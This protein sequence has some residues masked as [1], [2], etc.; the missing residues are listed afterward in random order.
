MNMK[1]KKGKYTIVKQLGQGGF[2]ITYLATTPTKVEGI[3]NGKKKTMTVTAN[4]V[5]KEFFLKDYCTREENDSVTVASKGMM[6]M[7]GK[8][9]EKFKK[10]AIKLSQMSHPNIVEVT[11]VI[12]DENNTSYYI[13]KYLS[14]GTL[15]Q[16]VCSNAKALKP[17]S[18]EDAVRYIKQVASALDYMHKKSMCHFD[19]KPNNIM[20]DEDGNAVLIDFGLAKN[21]TKEGE[22]TSTLISGASVGYAPLEQANA[23]LETFSP[24]TDIYA[25]GATLYFLLTGHAPKA[26]AFNL[27]EVLPK[28]QCGISDNLWDVIKGS[29]QANPENRPQN[30]ESFLRYLDGKEVE[31]PD[32]GNETDVIIAKKD[33]KIRFLNKL[34]TFK[35]IKKSQLI[36]GSLVLVLGLIIALIYQHLPEVQPDIKKIS[37]I[38]SAEIVTPELPPS[39]NNLN[40]KPITTTITISNYQSPLGNCSYTGPVDGNGNPHGVGEASFSDGRLYKGPFINGIFEGKDAFFRYDNGDTFQGEFQNNRFFSGKYTIKSDGSYFVGSFKNGQPNKGQWYDK[41]GNKI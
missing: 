33:K 13:M 38:D 31:E 1:L 4:V 3:V 8:Y 21:Y 22:Q 39:N 11:D 16:Q 6:E 18:E 10:E 40:N 29:M 30:I 15:Y 24:Q 25:L 28:G 26:A 36:V 17:L 37:K 9:R 34:L 27:S 20:L 7:V 5:V 2:G 35:K 23:N 32:R 12:E 14:G 19:V 41:N